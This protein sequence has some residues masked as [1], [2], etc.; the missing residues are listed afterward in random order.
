MRF[1]HCAVHTHK[2]GGSLHEIPS[3]LLVKDGGRER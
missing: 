1:D 3:Y 2:E